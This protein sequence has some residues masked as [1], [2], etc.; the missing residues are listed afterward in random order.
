VNWSPEHLEPV[1]DASGVGVFEREAPTGRFTASG[2]VALLLEDWLASVPPAERASLDDALDRVARGESRSFEV[3]VRVAPDRWLVVHGGPGSPGSVVGTVIDV[4]DRH[5]DADLSPPAPRADE[6][7]QLFQLLLEGV[8]DNAVFM[9][10]RSGHVATWNPAAQRVTDYKTDEIRDQHFGVFYPADA[11]A[12]GE[13]DLHLASAVSAG[14]HHEQGWRVRRGGSRFWASVTITAVR[15]T[16]GQLIGFAVATRDLTELHRTDQRLLELVPD[17]V[18]TCDL[19][20]RVTY[21][22]RGAQSTFGWTAEEALGRRLPDLIP[23]APFSEPVA[24]L[25]ALV[26]DAGLWEGEVAVCTK[27]G[28]PIITEASWSLRRDDFDR[29]TGLLGVARDVTARRAVEQALQASAEELAASNAELERFAYVASH[30]LSE[31]LRTVAGFVQLLA[32]RYQGRLDADADDFIAFAL[33]GVAHMQQLIE[34]LLTYSRVSRFDYKLESVNCNDLVCHVLASLQ[35][36]TAGAGIE[37]LDLPTVRADPRQLARVFQ[38]LI[39]NALKFVA[40]DRAPVVR[41]EA[42]SE[43]D[44]WRFSVADNGI[45]IDPGHRE[46]IFQMFQRLHSRDT[47]EGT[48]IG[49][50][51]CQRVVERHGGRIWVEG[52]PGEGSTFFF[53]IPEDRS[54]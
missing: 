41:I 47:Y 53:T 45:G 8:R 23:A 46:R 32:N 16:A 48:G 24:D 13:P 6:T 33:D 51:V 40:P 12:A 2:Y 44:G 30:D 35:S 54:R 11:A 10:D 27:D 25:V 4:S 34:D 1:L 26:T 50:A 9:L 52:A 36:T 20:K 18:M 38:N 28:R 21:W 42:S 5:P 14:R 7:E 15:D 17:A 31:P 29:P 49:L 43:A 39:S 37:V 3:E 22:N 19:D